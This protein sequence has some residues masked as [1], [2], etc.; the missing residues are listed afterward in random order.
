MKK[1]ACLLFI[2]ALCAGTLTGVALAT[3]E[4]DNRGD[5]DFYDSPEI[6]SW[7]EVPLP[8]HETLELSSADA[9][10]RITFDAR[11]YSLGAET[12]EEFHISPAAIDPGKLAEACWPGSR[13]EDYAQGRTDAEVRFEHQGQSCRYDS[14][15]GTFWFL[16][17][18]DWASADMY[19]NKSGTVKF[20]FT[21][22]DRNQNGVVSPKY[23]D[24]DDLLRRA[25]EYLAAFSPDV[26]PVL[27]GADSYL[28]SRNEEIRALE[29]YDFALAYDGIPLANHDIQISDTAQVMPG[30][31]MVL[32]CD[33]NGLLEMKCDL[34]E[35]APVAGSAREV[36]LSPAVEAVQTQ[37]DVFFSGSREIS[38]IELR[39]LPLAEEAEGVR[40][41]PCWCMS[42]GTQVPLSSLYTN[43]VAYMRSAYDGKALADS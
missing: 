21:V 8:E 36:Q 39:Y 43:S 40:Y 6:V 25:Q 11:V 15:S 22:K 32:I 10:S 35:V 26:T 34:I 12:A 1:F 9:E 17:E 18:P 31:Q 29:R 30:Q 27:I 7:I 20:S 19:A 28:L 2:F 33:A 16:R 5:F 14:E 13:V 4:N 37:E 3:E 41:A 23:A 24:L 42:T 38:L